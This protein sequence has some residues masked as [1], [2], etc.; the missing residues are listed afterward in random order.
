MKLPLRKLTFV[1][2]LALGAVLAAAGGQ[3]AQSAPLDLVMVPPNIFSGFIDVAYDAGTD[4]LTASGFAL[5]YDDGIGPVAP[6]ADGTFGLT[7]TIDDGGILSGGTIAIGG[8]IN[9]M[10]FISGT[11]L[12]GDITALGYPGNGSDVLEF[13]FDVT[14]GDAADAFGPIG[15]TILSGTGFGGSFA[16]AFDNLI[17]GLPGTGGGVADTADPP[18]IP[19]PGSTGLLMVTGLGMAMLLAARRRRQWKAEPMA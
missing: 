7:A 5:E 1:A 13:L 3:R 6:I 11:L 14:G 18:K 19:E 12:T 9:A 8:T 16:A 17:F 4:T 15:A 2:A 10:G